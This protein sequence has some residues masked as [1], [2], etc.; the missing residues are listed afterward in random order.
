F[1]RYAMQ[2]NRA[3]SAAKAGAQFGIRTESTAGQTDAIV[4]AARTDAQDT[5]GELTVGTRIFCKCPDTS[6]EGDC[7]GRCTDGR[8]RPT[9]VEV[10]VQDSVEL[11]FNYPGID[12]NLP[13]VARAKMR[14]R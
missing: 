11:M 6:S 1:G 7:S 4:L 10:T 5:A 2:Y 8:Y 12:P 13:I 3:Y 9:F 14:V